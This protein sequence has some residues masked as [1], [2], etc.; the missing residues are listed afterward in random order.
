MEKL[1][2]KKNRLVHRSFSQTSI[3][4]INWIH[5]YINLNNINIF[6]R[7]CLKN[8]D[9]KSSTLRNR[10]IYFVYHCYRSFFKLFDKIYP[11]KKNYIS[12]NF[13]PINIE[14]R[15]NEYNRL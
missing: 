13:I 12:K 15:I 9:K 4:I 3:K 7:S 14:K 5:K 6:L 2:S 10:L 11:Y 8:N 1:N